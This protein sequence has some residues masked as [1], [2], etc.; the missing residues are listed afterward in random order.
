MGYNESATLYKRLDILVFVF[1]LL[2]IQLCIA[3]IPMVL[4]EYDD[5]HNT[6]NLKE[7]SKYITTGIASI[8][9]VWIGAQQKLRWAEISER[10]SAVAGMYAHL[11][12][13]AN[14]HMTSAEVAAN[15]QTQVKMMKFLSDMQKLEE[16][17]RSGCPLPPHHVSKR[18]RKK[19]HDSSKLTVPSLKLMQKTPENCRPLTKKIN[20]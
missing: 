13:E 3:V 5:V 16:N 4:H 15:E 10:Y 12:S 7:I 1:P 9:A 19:P 20:K 8:S 11:T 2:A 6:D 17:A 18:H 14:Y